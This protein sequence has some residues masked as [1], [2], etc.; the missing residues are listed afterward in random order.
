M[1]F[2]VFGA[3]TAL[4]FSWS[5][6][7]WADAAADC[8]RLFGSGDDYQTVYDTIV[9]CTEAAE[10]G[11]AAAEFNLARMYE[12]GIGVAQDT[13]KATQLYFSSANKGNMHA[14]ATLGYYYEQGIIVE[15]NANEALRWKEL[16]DEQRNLAAQ[17]D[18]A[19]CE[20]FFVSGD[21]DKAF[22][23]CNYAAN[24]G[25]AEA[26][27]HLAQMYEYGMGGEQNTALAMSMYFDAAE[28]GSARAQSTL[29]YFYEYGINVEI[30][31]NEAVRWNKLA[32]E[33]GDGGAQFGLARAYEL[34]MGV[35]QDHVTAY[36]WYSV[37]NAEEDYLI[38]SPADILAERM[39]PAQIAEAQQRAQTCLANIYKNC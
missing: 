35:E 6:A 5:N 29:G 27:F 19:D 22:L 1:R 12:D 31:A 14:Q 10:Q 20:N 11:D 3:A 30:N 38:G 34:G 32:A 28:K 18:A 21:Y 13:A 8:E 33:Q 39:T 24:Q 23:P 26:K 17:K 16:A 36:M 25:D 7:A 9:A 4:V 2:K 15:K 37:I